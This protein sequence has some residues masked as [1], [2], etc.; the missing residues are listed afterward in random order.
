VRRPPMAPPTVADA[1]IPRGRRVVN[2][3]VRLLPIILAGYALFD[4]TFAWLHVPGIPLFQGEM[5]VTLALIVIAG[6]THTVLPGLKNRIPS[7]LLVVFMLWGLLRTVPYLGTFHIDAV[8]DAALWY[9]AIFGIVVAGLVVSI[10]HLPKLWAGS[11]CRLLP[12]VLLWSIPAIQLDARPGGPYLPDAPVVSWFAHKSGNIA[13]GGAMALAFLW[14]VPIDGLERRKRVLLSVLA[15]LLIAMTATQSRSGLIAAGATVVVTLLMSSSRRQMIAAM[16]APLVLIVG[17][18]WA[19]DLKI[20]AQP[21]PISVTQ[22]AMNIGSLTGGGNS[23]LSDTAQWRDQLWTSLLKETR[24]ENKLTSGWGFGENLAEKMGFQGDRRDGPL[25]SPH[26]SHLDVLA[27]MGVIGLTIWIALWIAWFTTMICAR[28]RASSHELRLTRGLMGFAIAAVVA[29]L[30]NAYFD[31]TLE[32]PQV[33]MWL[34]SLF[35]L[36]LGL[37]A[38]ERLRSEQVAA[39]RTA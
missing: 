35:G 23:Q 20:P 24:Q 22:L 33:A 5:M 29:I 30:V 17:L 36:G 28:R 13:V 27:R 34:W 6:A 4:R 19:I 39:S 3:F 38:R 11:Y 10:P 1:H 14:L 31:P 18:A 2:L 16:V 8:R 15:C 37:V 12:W 32:S 26:N 21:R 9:Y 7:T 25:R